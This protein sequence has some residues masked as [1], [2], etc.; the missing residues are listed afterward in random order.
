MKNRFPKFKNFD[1]TVYLKQLPLWGAMTFMLYNMCFCLSFQVFG[2]NHCKKVKAE[3]M[4]LIL[5][6]L[7]IAIL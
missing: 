3:P 2:L 7:I 1:D 5:Q 6:Q 4:W